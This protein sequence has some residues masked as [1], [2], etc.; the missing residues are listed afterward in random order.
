MRAIQSLINLKEKRTKE[1]KTRLL[2]DGRCQRG[3]FTKQETTSPTVARESV[4]IS[5]VIDANKRN[6]TYDIPGA[7]LNAGCDEDDGEVIMMPKGRL[8][9]MMAQ[10]SPSLYRKY[11]TLDGK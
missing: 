11:I 8:A 9:E 10:V 3:Q 5:A 2:A 6:N 7:F 1:I 4:I